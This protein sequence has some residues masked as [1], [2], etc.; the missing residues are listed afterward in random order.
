MRAVSVI[1]PAYNA[2]NYIGQCLDSVFKQTM[3]DFEIVVVNDGSTDR[4]EEA[5][6]EASERHPGR[7]KYLKQANRGAAVAR[8]AGARLAEG[9]VL[10]FID[11]DD[12]WLPEKLQI[13][14]D[15]FKRNPDIGFCFSDVYAIDASGHLG[16]T[17][18]QYKSPVSGWVLRNLLLE[19]F[20]PI[21]TGAV[22][23]KCFFRVNGFTEGIGLSEDYHLWLKVAQF[24]PGEYIPRPLACY[25]IHEGG[26][27]QMRTKI[28]EDALRVLDVFSQEYPDTYIKHRRHFNKGRANNFYGLAFYNYRRNEFK[29][30][31]RF[32]F[33][34][35]KCDL[36]H[37][38]SWKC[39][40][41]LLLIPWSLL[42]ARNL[43]MPKDELQLLAV[44][45]REIGD[46]MS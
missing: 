8:N 28:W 23:R 35:L 38:M 31:L 18:M 20:V 29:K 5:V 16:K 3:Q 14:M 24:W 46:S 10:A 4:T 34:S 40:A 19:N 27:S 30:A 41:T 1:V 7:I 45:E 25:R 2:Q 43:R 9:E 21:V 42:K 26:V 36:F 12:L 33:S 44:G 37:I 15:V 17:L 22:K 11:A 13:Q 6:L 32:L 39:A